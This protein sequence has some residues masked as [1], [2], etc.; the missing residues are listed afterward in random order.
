MRSIDEC[1]KR[2]GKRPLPQLWVDVNKGGAYDIEKFTIRSRLCA[3][4][5][6][7]RTTLSKDAS[8]YSTTPPLE[9]VVLCGLM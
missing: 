7:C 8:T 6:N 9:L 4:D 3:C 5:T 2:T 1:V